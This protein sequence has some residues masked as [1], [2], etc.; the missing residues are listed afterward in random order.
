MGFVLIVILCLSQWVA[1]ITFVPVKSSA[2]LSLKKILNVAVGKENSM[3]WDEAIYRRKV[4]LS[5]R[6]G[7]VSGGDFTR[8]PLM[9]NYLSERF[10]L[11]TIT[12]RRPNLGRNKGRKTNWLR[13]MRHLCT[14]KLEIKLC[15]LPSNVQE[16]FIQQDW[17]WWL[18]ENI[19]RRRRN[20]V[21]TSENVDIKLHNIK[22]NLI[23]PLLLFY[24]HLGLVGTKIHHF[25]EYTSKKCFNSFIQ[26]AV[27]PR[28]KSDENPSLSVVA[29]TMKLLAKV[30]MA[31]RLW[32]EADTL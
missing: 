9:L 16:R 14:Q 8:Q 24:L 3:N 4:S 19:C 23:T 21:S 25:V 1:F 6:R 13:S 31:I 18:D 11:Q 27:D 30:P 17:Y 12:Y 32:T 10:P 7:N 29:E 15:Q 5:L 20:K 26:T 2:H 28:R 22:W